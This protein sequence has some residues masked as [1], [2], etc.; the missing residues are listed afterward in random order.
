MFKKIKEF[1]CG[2]GGNT[3]SDIEKCYKKFYNSNRY[4]TDAEIIRRYL[5]HH[6]SIYIKWFSLLLTPFLA[7]KLFFSSKNNKLI[8]PQ[9]CFY[10][11]FHC[12]LHCESCHAL[13][14]YSELKNPDIKVFINDLEILFNTVDYIYTISL[15]GG[16]PFLN[17][18]LGIFIEYL[19]ENYGNQFKRIA[20]PTNGTVKPDQNTLIVLK[21]FNDRIDID[22]SNY[23]DKST[24]IIPVFEKFE[25]DYTLEDYDNEWFDTGE[26]IS[27]NRGKDE[28]KKLFWNCGENNSCNN[29]FNGEFHLCAKSACGTNFNLIP[30]NEKFYYNLRSNDSYEIKKESIKRIKDLDYNISCN[31]CDFSLKKGKKRK[32]DI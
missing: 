27:K 23:G 16:E 22:I 9:L 11:S 13:M 21:K 20:I 32:G 17:R 15:T 6:Q 5:V 2:G 3:S 10:V 29:I 12:N 14:E 26:P 28:L 7:I 19:F 1:L 25:I 8:F 31:Y 30:K 4:I 18:D 24:K